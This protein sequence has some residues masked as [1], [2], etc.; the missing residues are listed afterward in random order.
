MCLFMI[1]T[2]AFNSEES[3]TEFN[4]RTLANIS[5]F[6]QFIL[7]PLLIRDLV[8]ILGSPCINNIGI[9]VNYYPWYA[10]SRGGGANKNITMLRI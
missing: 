1:T 3:V 10:Y 9:L 8:V 6:H 2:V 5:S 7:F 4:L